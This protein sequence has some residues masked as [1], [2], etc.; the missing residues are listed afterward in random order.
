MKYIF[1]DIDGVLN[2]MNSDPKN[3]VYFTKSKSLRDPIDVK[4]L[5]LF[6]SILT[7]EHKIVLISSWCS[8]NED[9]NSKVANF[10]GI[11]KF[12]TGTLG[13]TGGGRERGR[14]VVDFVHKNNITSYVMVDDSIEHF[15][16]DLEK[17]FIQ[18]NGISGITKADLIVINNLLSYK[19]SV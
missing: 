2:S 4:L 7:D 10:L 1:L 15:V 16:Y 11:T 18:I 19:N 17:H 6:K 9:H 3:L 14:A 5:N 13:Y 12:Y 8:K